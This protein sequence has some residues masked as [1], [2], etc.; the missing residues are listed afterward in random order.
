MNGK[1]NLDF[2]ETSIDDLYSEAVEYTESIL[3][4]D[5]IKENKSSKK[6]KKLVR[7]TTQ[8]LPA[9]FI[10]QN[11]DLSVKELLH[12]MKIEKCFELKKMRIT[13]K[14]I[15]AK[16]RKTFRFKKTDC[17]LNIEKDVPVFDS[18]ISNLGLEACS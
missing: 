13:E 14:D 1:D 16:K 9:Y 8:G 10:P 18:L 6:K 17:L 5:P 4:G 3:A 11:A 2:E 15:G 12:S 7:D